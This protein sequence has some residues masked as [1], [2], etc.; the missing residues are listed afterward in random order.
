MVYFYHLPGAVQVTKFLKSM[1]LNIFT[2]I[3]I[4]L[5]SRHLNFHPTWCYFYLRTRQLKI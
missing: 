5:L 1:V 2:Q 4:L 3:L